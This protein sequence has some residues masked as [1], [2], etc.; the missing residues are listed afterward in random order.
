M[1]RSNRKDPEFIVVRVSTGSGRLDTSFKAQRFDARSDART[2]AASKNA[3]RRSEL[4]KYRV[5]PAYP[6]PVSRSK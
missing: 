6:G 5:I 3:S 1:A 2:F 4:K